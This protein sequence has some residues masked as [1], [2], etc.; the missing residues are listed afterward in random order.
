M[1]VGLELVVS[2][3]LIMAYLI[4]LFVVDEEIAENL[5]MGLSYLR[6]KLGLVELVELV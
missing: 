4:H 1:A 6:L 3:M 2:G 5:M